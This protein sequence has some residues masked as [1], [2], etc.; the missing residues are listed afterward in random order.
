MKLWRNKMDI[1]NDIFSIIISNGVFAILFVL[2]FCY[3]LKDSQK[4]ENK[5]EITIEKLTTHLDVL[6]EVKQDLSDIKEFLKKED[7]YEELL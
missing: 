2:L 1:W 3:Q 5:Y 7:A 6:E 4:R